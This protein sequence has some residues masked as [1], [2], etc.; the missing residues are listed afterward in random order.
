M[1]RCTRRCVRAWELER[2]V[3]RRGGI[4]IEGE[5]GGSGKG[6]ARGLLANGVIGICVTYV[7][8]VYALQAIPFANVTCVHRAGALQHCMYQVGALQEAT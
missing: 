5:G 2:E 8:Y 1:G 7:G 6:E 4:G 3:G